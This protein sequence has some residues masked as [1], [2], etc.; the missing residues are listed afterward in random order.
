MKEE[1]IGDKTMLKDAV[2]QLVSYH[3]DVEAI[4]SEVL[5][6]QH[7]LILSSCIYESVTA[8]FAPNPLSRSPGQAK[9]DSDR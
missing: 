3:Q 6:T 9:Q 4:L 5:I 1:L 8:V 2:N 7:N